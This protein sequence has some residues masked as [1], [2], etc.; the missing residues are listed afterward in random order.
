M[1]ITSVVVRCLPPAEDAAAPGDP[2]DAVAN[3]DER[4]AERA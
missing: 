2:R 1:R 3:E 4:S